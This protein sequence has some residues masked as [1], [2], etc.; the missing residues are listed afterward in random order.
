MLADTLRQLAGVRLVDED[1]NQEILELLPPATEA[2]IQQAEAALPG[3]LP[4]EIRDALR[5]SKGLANGPL[6]TFSLVDLEGFGLDEAFPHPHSIAHDGFGNY[7][8]LDLLPDSGVWGPVFFACHDPPVIAYQA[9][10]IE[11]FLRDAVAM[12]QGGPRSPVDVVHEDVV[13]RIWRENPDLLT[14]EAA[15]ASADPTLRG[16]AASLPPTALIADLRQ[17]RVGQGFSWGRYGPKTG[18]LRAG[19][20]R[21][22]AMVPP[23]RK[24]GFFGRLFGG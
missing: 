18:L 20:E 7:W 3:P 14:P 19:R 4:A 24:P 2:E 21:I 5:V 16:F 22:W 8:I 17:A 12:W 15:A 23:E 6:E 1:G 11:E 10:T 13:N 9:P